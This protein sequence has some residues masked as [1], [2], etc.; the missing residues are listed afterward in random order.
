[1]KKPI[2]YD[3]NGH[4]LI[5]CKGRDNRG[6][7]VTIYKDNLFGQAVLSQS[8]K[9]GI[10]IYKVGTNAVLIA[11]CLELADLHMKNVVQLG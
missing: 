4:H 1:M 2:H 9:E 7:F 10:C 5:V 8:Q 6:N 3:R 11:D